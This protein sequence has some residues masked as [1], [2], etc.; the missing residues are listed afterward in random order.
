MSIAKAIASK[1]SAVATIYLGA[2]AALVFMFVFD[3]LAY[4]TEAGP[5]A[6]YQARLAYQRG[7]VTDREA[8]RDS[9]K[10]GQIS[11]HDYSRFVFPAY[12]KSAQN[13]ESVFPRD[14][15]LKPI[16]QLRSEAVNV[17]AR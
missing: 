10:G 4:F 14:E 9:L 6:Y 17:I 12:V 16:A 8:I 3:P 1:K 13:G 15:R 2:S 7:D 11:T 5:S